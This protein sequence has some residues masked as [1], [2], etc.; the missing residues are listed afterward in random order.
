MASTLE[1]DT[2]GNITLQISLPWEKVKT[3]KQTVLTSFA[4]DMTL[5]G[6][7]KG[8][9]PLNVA[10][11]H[12]D[13]DRLREETLKM[14]LPD[15]YVAAVKEHNLNP[16]VNPKIH[17][18][19]LEDDKDWT[20]SAVTCEMPKVVLGDYKKKVKDIT[21]KSKIAIPGKEQQEPNFD[22]IMKVL[23]S[24]AEITVPEMIVE[25]EVD[26]LLSQTLDEVKKLGLTL[27]QYLSSTGKSA[28]Q[29]R[30]DYREKAIND[31][32][33]EFIL[34]QVA[35][36]EKITVEENELDEAVQ[37]AKSPQEKEYLQHNK[38][39]L[40]NILKQQKTLDFL[41]NL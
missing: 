20:F 40:A 17:V 23:V 26:R 3:A 11:E 12:I 35:Q 18:D 24:T 10:A 34:Q 39:M 22:E 31:I 1:R 38:Y 14:L 21:A 15:A 29:L 36:E 9:A 5:Q 32:K 33:M 19:K 16:I 25:Q 8:K 30:T 37:K 4:K 13:P 41:K 27:D 6:F 7:R 28:E 2:K